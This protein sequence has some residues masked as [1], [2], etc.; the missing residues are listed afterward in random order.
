[1]IS[2]YGESA[3]NSTVRHLLFHVK[4]PCAPSL[5][6][7]EIA[8]YDIKHVFNIHIARDL[9]QRLACVAQVLTVYIQRQIWGN[10][11]KFFTAR[12]TASRCRTLL[13]ATSSGDGRSTDNCFPITFNKL[14][15]PAPVVDEMD[16][17]SDDLSLHISMGKHC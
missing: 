8:K 2:K 5:T 9:S 4:Q 12:D 15:M 13:N 3:L 6:D 7:A 16:K 17:A 10:R 1:M 14:S 11:F